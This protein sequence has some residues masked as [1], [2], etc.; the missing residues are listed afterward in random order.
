MEPGQRLGQFHERLTVEQCAGLP[1]HQG[2]VVLRGTD[3]PDLDGLPRVLSGETLL[4]I[5]SSP[6]LQSNS[7]S[8]LAPR[9]TVMD[10]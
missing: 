8:M 2:P 5:Q 9:L 4:L 10:L 3:R 7:P 6:R 1:P